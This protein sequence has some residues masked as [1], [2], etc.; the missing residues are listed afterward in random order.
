MVDISIFQDNSKSLDELLKL[1]R[2]DFIFT[3]N[4]ANKKNKYIHLLESELK[5]V[6]PKDHKFCEKQNLE[7]KDLKNEYIMT[8]DTY[9]SD[10]DNCLNEIIQ[11]A[12]TD[13]KDGYTITK[14]VENK[15]GIGLL[16]DLFLKNNKFDFEIKSFKPN[17]KVNLYISYRDRLAL[18]RASKILIEY[19]KN[20]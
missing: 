16:S 4:R 14:M 19:I 6:L 17:L 12:N 3:Y 1:G 10:T 9:F 7:I 20:K 8:P 13:I 15:L 11:M 2:V 5:L 18:N